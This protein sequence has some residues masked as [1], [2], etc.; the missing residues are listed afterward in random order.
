MAEPELIRF[1]WSFRSP[2]AWLAVHRIESELEGLAVRLDWIPAYPPEDPAL[3]PNNPTNNPAKLPYIVRDV[4]RFADAYGLPVKWPAKID[5][6]WPRPHA[7]FLFAEEQGCGPAFAREGFAARFSRGQDVGTDAV[8][9]EIDQDGDLGL[10]VGC[11]RQTHI[12]EDPTAR[13]P[14]K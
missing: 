3:F 10:A 2:Y 1:Y 5:T 6:D 13:G 4:Q 7:A 12:D 14:Q 11:G 9:G 8:L